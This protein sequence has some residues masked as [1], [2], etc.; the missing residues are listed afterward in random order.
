MLK[1][2]DLEAAG[3]HYCELLGMD[4]DYDISEGNQEEPCPAWAE[5]AENIRRHLAAQ[6]ALTK[7][8]KDKG[9]PPPG[10]LRR[11]VQP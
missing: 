3:R 10:I 11:I 1:K 8:L 2:E 7:V 4:P 6:V 5:G 9:D